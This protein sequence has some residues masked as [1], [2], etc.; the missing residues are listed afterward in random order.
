MKLPNGYGSVYKLSG[1]RRR[2][3]AARLTVDFK[4][5]GQANYTY[6][7]YFA[8]KEEA[9]NCL[10]KYNQSPYDLK[11]DFTFREVFEMML[12]DKE[13]KVKHFQGVKETYELALRLIGSIADK[14]I[15][16]LRPANFQL[17]VD[18]K[19]K[20]ETHAMRVRTLIG[21]TMKFAVKREIVPPDRE[22]FARALD[23]SACTEGE[24]IERILYTKEEINILWQHKDNEIAR[25]LLILLYTGC[26]IGELLNAK[27]SDVN[28][29]EHYFSIK[30]AKTKAGIRD[31]AIP[32]DLRPFLEHFEKDDNYIIETCRNAQRVRSA[33]EIKVK[34]QLPQWNIQMHTFHDTRHTFITELT[35]KGVDERIIQQMVGHKALNVTREVY[36]HCPL[37]KKLEVVE[38]LYT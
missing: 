33:L 3:Y 7:G 24:K 22:G 17:I 25:L 13:K 38:G 5:N 23:F 15:V 27:Y 11:N 19:I 12:Q 26:R 18:S 1:N 4:E 36:T 30:D 28:V 34:R 37:S 9:L 20:T 2:P 14:K 10:A 29:Q 31:I 35:V 8:T 6:L 16:E 32:S 21:E